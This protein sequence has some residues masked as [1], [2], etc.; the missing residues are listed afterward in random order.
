MIPTQVTPFSKL[1]IPFH[2]INQLKTDYL[3]EIYFCFGCS[4]KKKKK[5]KYFPLTTQSVWISIE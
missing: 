5:E 3:R 1:N 2:S 4:Q